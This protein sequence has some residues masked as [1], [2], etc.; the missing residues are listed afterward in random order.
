MAANDM[1][2]RNGRPTPLERVSALVALVALA[3]AKFMGGQT[4][5]QLSRQGSMLSVAGS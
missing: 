5:S 4:G 1:T 2:G 3:G